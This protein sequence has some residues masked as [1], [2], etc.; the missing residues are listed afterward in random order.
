MERPQ[1]M[2][3]VTVEFQTNHITVTSIEFAG[4][5]ATWFTVYS[6]F[7]NRVCIK[8]ISQSTASS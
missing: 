5:Q 3:N 7:P 8:L 4:S 6:T 2:F 1:V